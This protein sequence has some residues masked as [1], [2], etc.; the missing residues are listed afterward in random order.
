[1]NPLRKTIETNNTIQLFL[2]EYQ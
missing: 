2:Y 1:M